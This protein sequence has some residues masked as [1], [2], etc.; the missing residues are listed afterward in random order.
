MFSVFVAVMLSIVNIISP[1]NQFAR[2]GQTLGQ[3]FAPPLLQGCPQLRHEVGLL[4]CA[5]AVAPVVVDPERDKG[6][7][8]IGLA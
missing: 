2:L 8:L 3:V 5:R 1:S 4:G 7:E 6:V